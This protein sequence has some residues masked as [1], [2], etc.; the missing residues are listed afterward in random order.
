M[1]PKGKF[2]S[3]VPE[4]MSNGTVHETIVAIVEKPDCT[5]R[6]IEN[7]DEWGDEEQAELV[8]ETEV[9]L[10]KLDLGKGK[11]KESKDAE[12]LD[13]AKDRAKKQ[14]KGAAD[15]DSDAKQVTE[16]DSKRRKM[17]HSKDTDINGCKNS[18]DKAPNTVV[19]VTNFRVSREKLTSASPFF[20]TMLTSKYFK[21]TGK[22]VIEL[23]C[24]ASVLNVILCAA[25][26]IYTELASDNPPSVSTTNL[27]ERCVANPHTATAI[28]DSMRLPAHELIT[29]VAKAEEYMIDFGLIGAWVRIWSATTADKTSFDVSMIAAAWRLFNNKNEDMADAFADWVADAIE[30]SE[31]PVEA[32]APSG[33]EDFEIPGEVLEN[34][35]DHREKFIKNVRLGINSVQ[36]S[37]QS[38]N[39]WTIAM[40]EAFKDTRL[41]YSQLAL[42][43]ANDGRR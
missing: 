29:V 19:Y 31:G 23:D 30:K 37:D 38:Y 35:N 43:C 14:K 9:S 13:F 10:E 27:F 21:D 5:I 1:E 12:D 22:D 20:K 16:K 4:M 8:K 11:A 42:Q 39:F 15:A 32:T 25:H 26:G 2:P 41:L 18:E 36:C 24:P 6:V 3:A 33:Y 17:E 34:M 7:E 28:L 40:A